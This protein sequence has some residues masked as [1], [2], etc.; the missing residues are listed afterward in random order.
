VKHPFQHGIGRYVPWKY[1]SS[2]QSIRGSI[3]GRMI[4]K[5]YSL[6]E[7]NGF[8]FDATVVY[9]F[10]ADSLEISFEVKG[11]RPVAAESSKDLSIPWSYSARRKAISP[12][13]NPFRTRRDKRTAKKLW[14]Y[15]PSAGQPAWARG[16]SLVF[17]IRNFFA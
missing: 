11:E 4:C 3:N 7:L 1:S 16:K 17:P 10:A 9:T 6:S 2:D 14:R 15:H 12:A 5:E 8:A 13:S